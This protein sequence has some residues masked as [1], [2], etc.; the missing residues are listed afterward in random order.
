[1][2]GAKAYAASPKGKTRGSQP[3]SK[4]VPSVQYGR[5]SFR[6][7]VRRNR[8]PVTLPELNLDD[9]ITD[10]SWSRAGAIMSGDLTFVDPA[11]RR[12]PGLVAKGDVVRCEVRSSPGAAWRPLWE[13]TV[14]TPTRDIGQRSTDI[15]MESTLS[16]AQS[17]KTA[18]RFAKDRSHPNGWGAD[19]VAKYAAK[20]MGIT[21]GN[22]AA[23]RHRIT[24]L[25]NKSASALEI[26][27][28]A[29]QQERD[30]TGRRFDISTGRGVLDVTEVRRPAYMLRLGRSLIEAVLDQNISPKF[31]SAVVVTSTIKT[32]ASTKRRK[33]R[34]LVVDRARVRRYGYIRRAIDKSGLQTE[35]EARKYGQDWLAR[36]AHPWAHINLTHAGIPWVQRGDGIRLNFPDELLTGDVYLLNATHTVTSG[37]Y[38]MNFDATITELYAIDAKVVRVA[39]KKAAV[40][41]ARKRVTKAK[42]APAKPAKAK[43][44]GL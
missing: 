20:R 5:T 6:L 18:W 42:T 26:I 41:K 34:V 21:L 35:A 12:L 2:T 7:T 38:T 40:A 28:A 8:G 33:L 29:Y 32:A 24:K 1:M 14:V 43:T 31:A 19:Q 30:S 10:F 44:R 4:P 37:S 9:V 23:A 36:A 13:M 17:T 27:T 15:Q 22:V 16:P 11:L 3:K 25:V 39:K